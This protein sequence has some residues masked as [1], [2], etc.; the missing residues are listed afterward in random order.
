MTFIQYDEKEALPCF[1]YLMQIFGDRVF[2]VKI[3]TNS[4]YTRFKDHINNCRQ[5]ILCEICGESF[6]GKVGTL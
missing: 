6:K 4:A 3:L 5:L 1:L 2:D